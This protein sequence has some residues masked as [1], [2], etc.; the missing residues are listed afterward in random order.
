M[1]RPV[2]Y[3]LSQHPGY[4][5]DRPNL[6]FHNVTSAHAGGCPSRCPS[7]APGGPGGDG[8]ALDLACFFGAGSWETNWLLAPYR[9]F[10]FCWCGQRPSDTP[11]WN[12]SHNKN[13]TTEGGC[14]QQ[15]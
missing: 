15:L 6:P 2:L 12:R 10:Y 8:F 4:A 11:T 7:A 14:R 3:M 5:K 1:Y 9:I 13:A